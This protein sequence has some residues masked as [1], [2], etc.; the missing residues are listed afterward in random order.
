VSIDQ[1]INDLQLFGVALREENRTLFE[2]MMSEIDPKLLEAASLAKDPFEV[3]AMA[4]IFKQQKMIKE[5]MEL[6]V[7]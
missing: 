4:L 2:N 6:K 3:I 5:L 1:E 7:Y